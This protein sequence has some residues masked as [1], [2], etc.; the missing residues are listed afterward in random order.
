MSHRRLLARVHLNVRRLLRRV[1]FVSCQ[2]RGGAAALCSE[3][4]GQATTALRHLDAALLHAAAHADIAGV[5]EALARGANPN[6]I[7]RRSRY[8]FGVGHFPDAHDSALLLALKS[9]QIAAIDV[10]LT[11]REFG[12]DPAYV[13]RHGET[14]VMLLHR[15]APMVTDVFGSASASLSYQLALRWAAEPCR[16]PA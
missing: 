5:R 9:G 4:G 14:A 16:Q 12:A 1:R 7:R 2:P 15:A 13:N 6:A 10:A 11:L 3:S 8:V